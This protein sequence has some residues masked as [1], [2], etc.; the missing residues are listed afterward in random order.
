[1]SASETHPSSTKRVLVVYFSQTGQLR[2]IVDS[3]MGPLARVP[4]VEIVYEPLRPVRPYPF[5]WKALDFCDAFPE[6]VNG[7]PCE[8]H[9]LA[10]DPSS[11]FDLI[12]LAYTVWFLAPSIPIHSLL[13]S[14]QARAI[15]EGRPVV[16]II[17]CRNMWILAQERVKAALHGLGA[18]LTGNVVLSD[19]AGNLV[20]V[21][22]IAL[23]M[24]TGR[25]KRFW[26]ILPLPGVSDGDIRD[27]SRF[28]EEIR[29][30]L[31]RG[32]AP[33]QGRL[34]AMGAVRVKRS[35]LL[36]EKRIGR[37]FK[38]WA[39]LIRKKGGPGDPR[40][41]GRVRIFLVY[42]LAAILLV[43]PLASLAAALLTWFRGKKIAAET[44]YYAQ[45]ALMDPSGP[46]VAG[47][48][49]HH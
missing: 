43:A 45:N 12:I 38:I 24:L 34:N 37:V 18:R 22:T 49:H 25:K 19:R 32:E 17:G 13:V 20:G 11:H 8:L 14:P 35:L 47:R 40:R 23:W 2:E 5:P 21:L 4:G 46:E 30:A 9:P 10:V 27:A 29:S 1:M 26:G 33:D 39:A 7:E 28:G 16:T 36:M 6:S 48:R 31:Q 44:A 15:F 41:R 42:L 3:V